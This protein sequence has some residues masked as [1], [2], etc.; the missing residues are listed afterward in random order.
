MSNKTRKG[1]RP[2]FLAAAL[3]VVAML[4]VAAALVLP[5]GSAQAQDNPFAPPAPTGVSAAEDSATQV[6]VTWTAGAGGAPASGYE[7]QRKV[8]TGAYVG[9]T[10]AHAGEMAV[11]VDT[12]VSAGMTYMYRVRATNNFGQSVWVESN[13][14]TV[15]DPGNGGNGMPGDIDHASMPTSY[16][17]QALDNGARLSWGMPVDVADDAS[18][19]GYQIEREAWNQMTN[20]PINKYG[21]AMIKVYAHQTDYSDLGLA[22]DTVYIYRVRALV[23]HSRDSVDYAAAVAEWWNTL[24][25][26]MMNDVVSPNTDEPAVGPDNMTSPYC[27]MYD[28]LSAGAKVVVQRAYDAK[29]YNYGDWSRMRTIE[30]AD[31]GGR[32]QA[33]LDP[34]TAV[35]MLDS[36]A[37][38]A[39]MIT[40]TWQEPTDFGT[41][42]TM[43]DN[44]VYVGPDYIGGRRAGK[45]EVGED[46]T[47]VTYQVQRMANNGPWVDVTPVGMSYTDTPPAIAYENTYKYRVRAMNVAGLYGPWTMVTEV[48]T[49]PPQPMQPTGL[50]V[51]ATG[52]NTVELEWQAPDDPTGLWS[53]MADFNMMGAASRNLEYVIERQVADAN[54]NVMVDW[55]EIHTQAHLYADEFEDDRTQAWED[56]NAPA[57]MVNYRVSA[58]VDACNRSPAHQKN[59]IQV[60]DPPPVFGNVAASSASGAVTITWDAGTGASSHV[61]IAVNAA[62]DTDFCMAVKASSDS[63]HTCPG[64]NVGTSYVV[65]VIALDGAGGYT[66]G[67]V[68]THTVN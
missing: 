22:Y 59:A 15:A 7:V 18:I 24:D 2:A 33:L 43:D 20:H 37:A 57:G 11:Y 1:I 60:V 35:R 54:G 55:T 56:K 16:A 6:T 31:S 23:R 30:T 50:V 42:P 62:D 49:E 21:D 9:A 27:K 19:Y 32:L 40:V 65:L 66:L 47:S 5:S 8:G 36:N 28:G 14:V 13:S 53:T 38:C 64:L 51:Q 39:N 46:A 44:G 52:P 17:L 12:S 61:V 63:E 25:C 68:V 29:G 41:V 67:N 58:L 10:P 4:A 3:G 26:P 34:P 48:L 45:E